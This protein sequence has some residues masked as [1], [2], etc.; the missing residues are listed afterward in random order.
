VAKFPKHYCTLFLFSF[1]LR[2][3]NRF[4]GFIE[5]CGETD[6]HSKANG[7]ARTNRDA[8]T[9]CCNKP[10]PASGGLWCLVFDHE[11]ARKGTRPVESGLS[12]G[13]GRSKNYSLSA[14][15]CI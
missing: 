10:M 4:N 11:F 12:Q 8:D 3:C 7:I 6:S 2:C 14:A 15:E 13:C 5:F 1:I 9:G